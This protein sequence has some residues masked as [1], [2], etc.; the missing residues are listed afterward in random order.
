MCGLRPSLNS[1]FQTIDIN[2]D[3]TLSNLHKTA[4]VNIVSDNQLQYFQQIT[5]DSNQCPKLSNTCPVQ[6]LNTA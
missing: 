3:L 6:A 5:D 4:T 2:S 1:L